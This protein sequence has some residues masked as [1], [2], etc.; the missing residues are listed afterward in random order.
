MLQWSRLSCVILIVLF[1]GIW[2]PSIGSAEPKLPPSQSEPSA[3]SE[4][5]DSVLLGLV[6]TPPTSEE[7]ALK[8]LQQIHNTGATAVRL[9]HLPEADA[10]FSLADSLGLQLFVDLPV[11]FGSGASL[12]DSLDRA[13]SDLDRVLTL[14]RRHP[15]VQHV[16]LARYANTTEPLT[17]STLEQ[18]TDRLHSQSEADLST[19][20]VTPFSASADRCAEAVDLA[21][22]DVRGHSTP[23]ARW[24]EWGEQRE[25]VGLGA[26]GTWTRPD[27]G[28]GLR[29]PHSPERQARYL[30]QALSQLLDSLR[31]T[32]PAVF[33]HR[34]QDQN[35]P[36]LSSRRY[37][38][39]ERD[40]TPRPAASVVRGRYTD[41]KRVFAFPSGPSTPSGPHTLLLLGWGLI[42]VLGGLY[43]RSTFV[44]NTLPRYFKA[45]GFYRDALR[46]GRK[47]VGAIHGTLLVLVGMA[48][49]ITTALAV[50]GAASLPV[51]EL[52]VAA[53]PPQL[54]SVLATGLEF[55]KT[56]GF[57][58]GGAALAALFVWILVLTLVARR[59]TRFSLS[60]GL[61]LVVW[62]CWP[63]LLIMIIALVTA[64]HPPFSPTLLG[65]LLLLYSLLAAVGFTI[66]VLVDYRAVTDMPIPTVVLL[67]ALSPVV[68]CA[69]V[70]TYALLHYEV[71]ATLLWHLAT[72]T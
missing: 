20:Y 53:I 55:P 34:W 5:S 64:T 36:V 38:L 17:C 32:P 25:R 48:V 45:H 23:L 10:I 16:G 4:P 22:L 2:L 43:S 61:M 49:A 7:T 9:T 1:V 52:I 18:W 37:G 21:L 24:Q 40:G 27:A 35:S 46:R 31:T 72:H 62:P 42:A 54:Q 26:L 28:S 3:V 14:V 15:S 70:V 47:V 56:T 58:I 44:R 63:V 30:E 13:Q 41:T 39:H 12:R 68:L 8:A 51:S 19:Y 50:R 66:R 67:G 29:V 33:V 71:D 6:W 57:L 65:S 59:W 69:A 60:Q 11:E